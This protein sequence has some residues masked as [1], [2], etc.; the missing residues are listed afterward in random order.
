MV[1]LEARIVEAEVFLGEKAIWSRL[2]D[3]DACLRWIVCS[4]ACGQ[5]ANSAIC[6]AMSFSRSKGNIEQSPL[7]ATLPD[8]NMVNT[9]HGNK[10]QRKDTDGFEG[11]IRNPVAESQSKK[12]AEDQGDGMLM[13]MSEL[14]QS[15]E[16]LG[17]KTGSLISNLEHHVRESFKREGRHRKQ[18]IE[19]LEKGMVVRM[20]DGCKNEECARQNF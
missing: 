16:T 14:F 2:V 20:E 9:A 17:S 12:V 3:G 13:K 5:H 18:E 4:S 15:M 19:D 7:H 6:Q 1:D 11:L 8:E 10:V